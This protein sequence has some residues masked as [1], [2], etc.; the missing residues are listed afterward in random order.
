MIIDTEMHDQFVEFSC[1][2]G[3]LD[4]RIEQIEYGLIPQ[5]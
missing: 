5:S 4:F 1:K 3:T 2:T